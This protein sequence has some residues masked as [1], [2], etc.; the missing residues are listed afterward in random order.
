MNEDI[1]SAIGQLLALLL[2]NLMFWIRDYFL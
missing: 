2:Q 1:I